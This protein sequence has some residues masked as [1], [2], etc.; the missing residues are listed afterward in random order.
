MW[1]ETYSDH[2]QVLVG[3]VTRARAEKFKEVLNG[4]IQA[5]WTQSNSWRPVEGIAQSAQINE[6][7]FPIMSPYNLYK[8]KT[9]L[10]RNLV[11]TWKREGYTHLHLGGV[12]LI[13]TLHG[14][15]GLPVTARIALIDTRFKEYQHAV[16]GTVLKTLHAGSVLLTFYPN[17]NLSLE[18]PNL[19]TTLKVQIQLQGA[20]QTPTSKIAT[21]HHQ[22]VYRLQNHA[23]DLPTPYTT[24]DALM[25]LADTD[26]IPTIIQILKQIQKQELLK[27]MPLEW[28]TNYEHFHQNSERIQTTKATF[29]RR[30]NG[31]V[32]LSFQT[33]DTK[34]VSDS[35][36]LSYTAMITAVQ[37]GQE[38][39]LPIHGFSSEGYPVYPNKINGHFIWDVPEAHMCNPD[40]P[41][42]DDT[43]ID[44][45][46][47]VMRRKKKKKKKSSYPPS[48]CKPFPPHPP[49]DPKPPVHPLRSCL[50][51]SSHSYEE[52]FPPLEKQTDTQTRVTSKPF[53]QTPV[54]AYGQLEEPKQYEAVLNW[55][56]KNAS[57]QN[58]TLQQLG[59]K[60]DRVASQVSQT[61]TKVDSI[62]SRLDQM[63]IHLQDR[64]SEL[65]TDLR[66]MIN[67]HIWGPEFNK[68]EAEIRKLKAELSRIDAEKTRPS[69]FTQPQPTPVSPP[70]FETYAPFY[71]PSQPQ[72]PVYNQFFD[73]LMATETADPSA[74]TSTP[75]VDDSPSDQASHTDPV[76][77]PVHEHSTKSSSASWFTFDDIPHHKWAARL[78]EFAAWIDLQG[79]KPN[80]QPQA[81]LR[82]FMARSTGFLRDWL[83]SLGE[84]RQLQFMESP[85]GTALNLIHEQFIGEKIASTEVDRKEYHQMKCCSLKRHLLDAHY[86]TMS[87]LFYKLNGFNEPSLKH[88]SQLDDQTAFLIAESSDSEDISVIS[89]VQTVNHVSTIPRPSL[90]MSILPSKFHKPILVI[91]FIDTGA[92]TS[93]I[94]PYVLPSDC[95]EHHSKLF[96]A[97]N[98]ETFETTLITKKP[99]G[100]QFF[101]NCIIWKKIVASKLPDKDLLIGFDILHL[102]KNLFLTSSGVRYKQMFL[103]YTDTLRLYALSETPF[104]YSHISQKLL[105]FCP[106]NHSQFHYPSP[107][108]KNEQFFIHLPFKLNED[109]DP[110]KASHP[111]MS[112]SDLLLAKQECSQLLQQGLIESTDSDWACQAFYVE[113][114]SELV[115]GKK[116]LVI[117]YQ[118]LNSFLKDD[119][120]PF[121]KIQTLFVHLQGA[122]IFSKFDLKVGFWQL[123][124]S[125]VDCHK[126][127]FCIPDA[128]YQWTIMPFGLKVAPSLFQ[129][130]MKKI[131]NPILHHALVYID[132]ILLF[133]S[134][135]ESHQKL[136]L[137][138]FHIVQAHGIMLSEKKSSVGKESIDFLGMVIKDG[139]YQPG[140]HIA[141]EIKCQNKKL[142]C[143]LRSSSSTGLI[144]SIQK[145]RTTGHRTWHMNGELTLIHDT[146]VS[147][148]LKAYLMELNN[149]PPP[150]INIHHTS[151]G[152]SHTLKVIPK[153]QG[154]TLGSSSSPQG[155]LVMEQ[156]PDYTNV[157]FQ[158]SQDPWEDFQSLLH[159]E[160]P[161]YTVTTPDSPAASTS[162]PMTEAD[163]DKYPQA[164][165]Y[166]DQRQIRRHKRQ[167]EKDTRDVIMITTYEQAFDTTIH[168][169]PVCL[170]LKSLSVCFTFVKVLVDFRRREKF[171]F[172]AST[173]SSTPSNPVTLSSTLSL[174]KSCTSHTANKI[175]NLVEYSYIPESAQISES[176]YP[177]L[178]PYQLYKRPSSFT[179]SIRTLISTRRPHP[180]EYIQSSCLDQCSLQAT[181][182]EQYVTLEI[183]SEL[184]SNWKREGF[185]HLHL[186]GI[187]LI[188]TLHGRKGLPVTARIAMLD[189]RFKQ[190]QDAVI[191]TVLTT[192]HAGSVL[193]TFYPNF[194]LSLQDPNLPTTLKV[195][196]QIQG[197]TLHHQLVYRLQ[198]HALDLPTPEHHSDTLMV[199]AESDQIPTIIQ[200]PRQIPSHE[201][202][203]LMPLEWISN[204][205]Q[206]YNN[207]APIQTSESMFERRQDGTVIMTFKPPSSAPQ[208]PP[209]L[210]FTYSSMI[211][212]VQTAQEDLP[213]TGFCFRGR[214][215]FKDTESS[216]STSDSEKS[217][218]DITKILMAQPQLS[219]IYNLE[220]MPTHEAQ[221]FTSV[222]I[223][224]RP[225][226]QHPDTNLFWT[227]DQVYE[228][229]TAPHIAVIENDIQ[230][231]LHNY[232]CQ[233]NH[234]PPPLKDISHTSLGPQHDLLMIP[235]PS[236]I[237]KPKSTSII[238]KEERPDYTDFLYQDSQDP[239]EDFLPLSQHLHQFPQPTMDEPGPSDPGPSTQPSK[240][241]AQPSKVDKA[242]QTSPKY[243]PKYT[244]RDYNCPYPPCCGPSCKHPKLSKTFFQKHP[245]SGDT[246]PNEIESSSEDDYMNLRSP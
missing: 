65:D 64:I 223:I 81:V 36:Q 75:I 155:I 120:F 44:E 89:T 43:D 187:R 132:D 126:T 109:I 127:A 163:E 217:Y 158:D 142:T 40:C 4:F 131:F 33:P 73:I 193:L 235:T 136:L 239:W 189:T 30:P 107:L 16:I 21:L 174:P 28:L 93:M 229:F 85:I 202:I 179:R 139:Q 27:L 117:D 209:R 87:I 153:T 18:D 130:A 68:K 111:G 196:V 195:Q 181:P 186:G 113:K 104:L 147:S 37:T 95:W 225:Y 161:H 203:K 13:L 175:E 140:P 84:Y 172:M 188:L 191:G 141:I 90:K 14:R 194:N 102:V 228:W 122:R 83:E 180:K 100:I 212:T 159:T 211:T 99:V 1:D 245:H 198:N 92:D 226:F 246:D 42:L 143:G 145:H 50:M 91:G 112:P 137:D 151:I 32:K 114:R 34:P 149:V 216:A 241:P 96:R 11:A 7:Q 160:N 168:V 236:A 98:G 97:V 177:L 129:K 12:R 184:I 62:S 9:S 106:E 124:I 224:H 66:R 162:Q 182:V 56:T 101:L 19:P 105:E 201:L 5:T 17:F 123:G 86:K 41:C 71:T 214:H 76:P 2:I 58:Q 67:N 200:I 199:L 60:I 119:K 233:L 218:A 240:R 125:P 169:T 171:S 227:Q 221:L 57:A 154:C 77:P 88:N 148:V 35:P 94:D 220:R 164:E 48:S 51:F 6:S 116:R 152:P 213:I 82:E 206:F 78:Q 237:S 197:A 150:A 192:L 176:S 24:S 69:L 121:P 210:S 230:D 185:T 31:Q 20:E 108:W 45:E 53:V 204:Y 166:L 115:R 25:I 215:T 61:E 238:I 39:K 79:T 47:E 54:I 173:S 178:S 190:Y 231:V 183:P 72:Q 63:Y 46:L 167:Y 165:A 29:D 144:S 103:P 242:T 110:T 49:P 135:H 26:T 22:I 219:E 10:T 157:L 222:F 133:S 8:E 134:D 38:K 3:L 205:E 243:T 128:H 70:F 232:L 118:P 59:K 156:R 80:A 208:E 244:P 207:T 52:S 234:Q 15:K 138:F 170:L 23:L 146:S 55:Q 74:Y